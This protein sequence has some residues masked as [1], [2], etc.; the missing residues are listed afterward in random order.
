MTLSTTEA[1]YMSVVEA[2]WSEKFEVKFFKWM[3]ITTN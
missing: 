3:K 2:V 1:E